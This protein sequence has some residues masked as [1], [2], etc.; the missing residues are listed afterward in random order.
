MTQQFCFLLAGIPQV[1]ILTKIDE[2]CPEIKADLK[3]VYRIQYVKDKVCLIT[4]PITKQSN[5]M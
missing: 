2:V 3:S 4:T 1:V 5:R